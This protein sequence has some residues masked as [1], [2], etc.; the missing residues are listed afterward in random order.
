[1]LQAEYHGF[2]ITI[3]IE[4][5]SIAKDMSLRDAIQQVIG[6]PS[7]QVSSFKPVSLC[8]QGLAQFPE[9]R[10]I[11]TTGHL[12]IDEKRIA[13]IKARLRSLAEMINC[14]RPDK[15]KAWFCCHQA[16]PTSFP[17]ALRNVHC[18]NLLEEKAL[19]PYKSSPNSKSFMSTGLQWPWSSSA[20]SSSARSPAVIKAWH[21]KFSHPSKQNWCPEADAFM[22]TGWCPTG[23]SPRGPFAVASC[24]HHAWLSQD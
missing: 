13:Y 24:L 4:T 14:Y 5:L 8:S 12:R 10:G 3:P 1:M 19:P 16:I 17:G 22:L 6:D 7:F 9:C 2:G 20:D 18:A 11:L 15:A 21:L 23:E